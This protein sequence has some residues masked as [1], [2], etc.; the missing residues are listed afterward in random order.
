M[1]S[2]ST[3]KNS[4]KM[5]WAAE[6]VQQ[7]LLDFMRVSFMIADHTSIMHDVCYSTEPVIVIC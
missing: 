5:V 1:E 7:K 2:L 6:M 3:P 4:Y